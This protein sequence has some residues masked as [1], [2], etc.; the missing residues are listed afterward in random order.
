MPDNP[1]LI[2]IGLAAAAYFFK[3]W[4]DDLKQEKLDTPN[5][6]A[7]PGATT[8]PR[9]P[10]I[11]GIT[12]ALLI[13]AAE[14]AGEYAFDFVDPQSDITILFALSSIAAAFIEEFIFRGFFV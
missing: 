3:L 11:V 10:I 2:L 7:F 1:L 14:V 4:L 12:G 9:L 8:A 6:T 5:P 13:L